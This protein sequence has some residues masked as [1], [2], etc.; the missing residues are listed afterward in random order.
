MVDNGDQ[1]SENPRKDAHDLAYFD[2]PRVIL[3]QA[4]LKE[5]NYDE[6]VKAMR[7][8]LQAKKKLSFVEGLILKPE[9]GTD[10]EEEW[11]TINTMIGSW[12]LNIMNKKSTKYDVLC[13]TL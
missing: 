7:L 11:W 3:T 8:A 1:T 10:K 12:I 2:S 4:Q 13:R 6:W 5:D 9:A